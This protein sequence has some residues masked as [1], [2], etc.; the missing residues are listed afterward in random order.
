MGRPWGTA[1]SRGRKESSRESGGPRWEYSS[2]VATLIPDIC[3]SI[4]GEW[5][6]GAQSFTCYTTARRDCDRPLSGGGAR[7]TQF[8]REQL[9][10]R[11]ATGVLSLCP[12]RMAE[13]MAADL[14]KCGLDH[15]VVSARNN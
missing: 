13:D 10:Q 3:I 5:G 12:E 2:E 14:W 9:K 8:N 15:V 4:T 11:G 1:D 6:S 7:T